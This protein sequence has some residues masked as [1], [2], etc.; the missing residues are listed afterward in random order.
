MEGRPLTDLEGKMNQEN[1]IVKLMEGSGLS[2]D[3][4]GEDDDGRMGFM[5]V[6]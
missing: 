5:A 4:A 6:S 2:P 3:I 1:V